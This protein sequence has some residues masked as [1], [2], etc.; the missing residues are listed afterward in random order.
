[1]G[2]INFNSKLID[3]TIKKSKVKSIILSN[4]TEIFTKKSHLQQDIQQEIFPL[5]HKKKL[6]RVKNICCWCSN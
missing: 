3:I 4:G 2:E 6:N 1:M 5:L